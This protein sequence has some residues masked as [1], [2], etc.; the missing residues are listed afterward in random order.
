MAPSVLSRKLAL[1]AAL[2]CL[3]ALVHS[4]PLDITRSFARSDQDPATY[5]LIFNENLAVMP[6]SEVPDYLSLHLQGQSQSL[7]VNA[8]LSGQ[9]LCVG[10]LQHGKSYSLTLKPG[11]KGASGALLETE[12]QHDFTVADAPSRLRLEKGQL[13]PVSRKG[14]VAVSALNVSGAR[15]YVYRLHPQHLTAIDLSRYLNGSSEASQLITLLRDHASLIRQTEVSFKGERNQE[16]TALIRLSGDRNIRPGLYYVVV[17]DSSLKLDLEEGIDNGALYRAFNEGKPLDGKLIEVSDLALTLFSGTD[18]L[19]ATVRSYKNAR[20]LKD[21]SLTLISQ[22]GGVLGETQSSREGRAFF[23]KTLLEGERG[24]RPAYLVARSD[25]D[26]FAYDLSSSPLYIEEFHSGQ[27]VEGQLPVIFT[28]RDLY[29]PGESIYYSAYLRETDGTAVT[30][31]EY[32]LKVLSPSGTETASLTLKDNGTGRYS[33]V[34]TLPKA[35]PFG[36]WTLRLED[37]SGTVLSHTGLSVQ[38][39]VPS[40]LAVSLVPDPSPDNNNFTLSARY[41]YGAPASALTTAATLTVRPE[42]HPYPQFKDYAFGPDP[43][44]NPA[45]TRLISLSPARTDALGYSR[46]PMTLTRVPYAQS[47]TLHAEVYDVNGERAIARTDYTVPASGP[48]VGVKLLEGEPGKLN[49]EAICVDS[50]GR[51]ADG[52]ASYTLERVLKDYQYV[53]QNGRWTFREVSLNRPVTAGKLTFK[54][55]KSVTPLTFAGEDGSYLVTFSCGESVT[56][57]ETTLGFVSN[58]DANHPDRLPLTLSKEV[59]AKGEDVKLTFNSPF[60]GEATLAVGRDRVLTL[61]NLRVQKGV[62]HLTLPYHEEYFPRSGVLLTL[63]PSSA[64]DSPMTRR[65]LAV[66]PLTYALEERNPEVT[67]DLPPQVQG[68]QSLTVPVTVEGSQERLEAEAFLVDSGILSLSGFNYPDPLKALYDPQILNLKLYDSYGLLMSS[69]SPRGQGYGGMEEA[70]LSKALSAESLAALSSE[71]IALHATAPVKDGK[72]LLNFDLPVFNGEMHL[73]VVLSGKDTLVKKEGRLTVREPLVVQPSLPV[74]LR[75]NERLRASVSLDNT[76]LKGSSQIQLSVKCQGSLSCD[77]TQK[78]ELSHGHKLALP[79]DLTALSVGQGTVEVTAQAGDYRYARSF[80]LPVLSAFSPALY[81]SLQYVTAGQ[82]ATFEIGSLFKSLKALRGE[83]SA[84]PCTYP[85][86]EEMDFEPVTVL[87]RAAKVRILLSMPG[88]TDS[89]IQDAIDLLRLSNLGGGYFGN[90][91]SDYQRSVSHYAIE[92]LL[93]AR[94]RGYDVG[95]EALD[96]ALNALQSSAVYGTALERAGATLLLLRAGDS[97]DLS[98]LRYMLDEETPENVRAL[99]LLTKVF[100]AVGD[101]DRARFALARGMEAHEQHQELRA[102]LSEAYAGNASQETIRELYNL[103]EPYEESPLNTEALDIIALLRAA[104][105]LEDT[106]SAATLASSLSAALSGKYYLPL[107][108]RAGLL[109][110]SSTP[111]VTKSTDF[112]KGGETTVPENVTLVNDT[113]EAAFISIGAVGELKDPASGSDPR[114]QITRTYYNTRGEKLTPPLTLR[115]GERLIVR[116]DFSH[117]LSDRENLLLSSLLPSGMSYEG[118]LGAHALKQ[119]LPK[120]A[121]AQLLN[122]SHVDDRLLT[123]TS[124]LRNGSLCYVLRAASPGNYALPE[125]LLLSRTHLGLRSVVP[126]TQNTLLISEQ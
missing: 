95:L 32:V 77:L 86:P 34:Y 111:P 17:A 10:P 52:S 122:P 50:A 6:V 51:P 18:G 126:A 15:A 120:F 107:S 108:E 57:F 26:F 1:S 87:D 125:S 112:L 96:E 53:L 123:T 54:D 47:A 3:P 90:G 40:R 20:A 89:E 8:S 49:L 61:K 110:L 88:S 85:D 33:T 37:L 79:L 105:A 35:A 16:S 13:L 84:L 38:S 4:A 76:D 68:G 82:S 101:P 121:Q 103:M 74:Y 29:R 56:T 21:V 104:M 55:G 65:L 45:L 19:H 124:W 71:A 44:L 70:L 59:Y 118:E 99:A 119:T 72:A 62:N 30:D 67:L 73:A 66:A 42:S 9:S 106:E 12:Q 2:L 22:S 78:L 75:E 69:L 109:S 24:D 81:T 43:R 91:W 83:V 92:T 31:G 102:T 115:V 41:N 46:M 113:G 28:D 97:V 11:L 23:D 60:K 27:A 98:S 94:E 58:L 116:E 100:F 48:M 36:H 39:F 14:R 7:P 80:T 25:E 64:K 93:I 63:Y 5:C 117:R 114:L